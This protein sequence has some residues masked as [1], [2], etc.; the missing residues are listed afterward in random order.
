MIAT[1]VATPFLTPFRLAL[2]AAVFVAMPYLLYQLWAF[3]AP[4]LYR[5]EKRLAVPLLV[6]SIV[7]FYVGV[8]FAYYI[9]FPLIFS[10]FVATSPG[11]G[12]DDD[13]HLQVPRF[14]PGAVFRLRDGLR[15]PCRY[16]PGSG[17]GPR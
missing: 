3:V 9:V 14:R 17:R 8:A 10:F 13:G 11:R 1:E 7:L 12:G 2:V 16:R 5:H 6:S 15:D 4:G